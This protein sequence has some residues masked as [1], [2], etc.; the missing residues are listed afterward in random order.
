[1]VVDLQTPYGLLET[2]AWEA[3]SPALTEAISLQSI[4]SGERIEAGKK[5]IALRFTFRAADRTLMD[6]EVDA[7]VAAVSELLRKRAGAERR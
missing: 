5:S 7:E 1:V 4:Y 3:V 2:A 6:A